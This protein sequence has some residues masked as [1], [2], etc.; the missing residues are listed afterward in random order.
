MPLIPRMYRRRRIEMDATTIA[1]ALRHY[2]SGLLTASEVANKLLYGLV[3]EE[4]IDTDLV[5]AMKDL[6]DAIK[7]EVS[8]LLESIRQAD[9]QWT[10]FLLGV[11][12]EPPNLRK[13]SDQVRHVDVLFTRGVKSRNDL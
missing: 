7:Q 8:A 2:E 12:T 13:Y 5:L 9:Y 10:P 1:R 4:E 3:L 6:P 11:R